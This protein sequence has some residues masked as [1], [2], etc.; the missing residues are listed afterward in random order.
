MKK[1]WIIIG[2]VLLGVVFALMVLLNRQEPTQSKE[3]SLDASTLSHRIE[4][5]GKENYSKVRYYSLLNEINGLL[6]A[7][8]IGF[9]LANS[10][11]KTIEYE[12]ENSLNLSFNELRNSCYS[13]DASELLQASKEIKAAGFEIGTALA[14]EISTYQH[15]QTA[16]S[17][18]GQLSA[19]LANRF[20]EQKASA[21]INGY[22]AHIRGKTFS[23]CPKIRALEAKL[24][25]EVNQ[26]RSFYIDY[27]YKIT[28]KLDKKL[29]PELGWYDIELH[30]DN[31]RKLKRYKFYSNEIEN[32]IN[33]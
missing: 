22:S 1:H 2:I 13:G 7:A 26:F 33:Q 31:Y 18:E 9:D 11:K 30:P 23:E 6:S 17:Y 29:I 5:L 3:V 12:R 16:L 27:Q 32:L 19:L 20:D 4:A 14:S 8:E 25:E 15:Y 10:Y 28:K 24:S 21:L